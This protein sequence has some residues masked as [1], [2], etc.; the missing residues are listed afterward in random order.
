MSEYNIPDNNSNTDLPERGE[1]ERRRSQRRSRR[2]TRSGGSVST[3]LLLLVF[4]VGLCLL[5]YPSISDMVNEHS[6][7]RV[8]SRYEQ[9]VEAMDDT[10]LD[11]IRMQAVQYN[12]NLATAHHSWNLSRVEAEQY[13]SVLDPF[14]TGMMG[15]L[16]IP[17]ID[18]KLP[19]YH[20]TDE[21]VLQ[22]GV[23]HMEG[24]SLPVG[25]VGSHCV[26]TGHRGLP[27]SRLLTDLDQMEYGDVF[28]IQVLNETLAYTVDDIRVVEPEQLES[29]GIVEGK[30]Y[31]TLVTCTPYGVNTHRL[32][33]RGVRTEYIP[34]EQ[35]ET[36]PTVET[37]VRNLTE[38]VPW[39]VALALVL[40]LVVLFIL[41]RKKQRK[42]R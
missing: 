24:S 33:V 15:Y 23:G 41:D 32:L 18:V 19:I 40:L 35:E 7:S 26:L 22:V 2:R 10:A 20:G 28:Y 39:V 42:E 25:G 3:L 37:A 13:R 27:S 17:S 34:P 9:E 1:G 6:Q 29:L 11:D 36:G 30:D 21:A 38:F 31:C 14:G 4:I 16:N 8:I 12:Q 5:L